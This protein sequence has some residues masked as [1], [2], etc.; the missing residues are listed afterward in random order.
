ETRLAEPAQRGN[1]AWGEG[2]R[3]NRSRCQKDEPDD[4]CSHEGSR[5]LHSPSVAPRG[6]HVVPQ[7]GARSIPRGTPQRPR[8]G[9]GGLLPAAGLEQLFGS[10]GGRGEAA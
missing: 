10:Q 3:R 8:S 4:G 6:S 2:A 7:G 9:Y 5:T 1:L